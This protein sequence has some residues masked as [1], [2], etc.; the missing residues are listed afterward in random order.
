MT[1]TLL[2]PTQTS[3]RIHVTPETLAIWRCTGRYNL[4]FVKI[5][6]KVFYDEADVQAFIEERKQV[7]TA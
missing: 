5:G 3:D 2:T 6:R 1:S 7:Q 4:K